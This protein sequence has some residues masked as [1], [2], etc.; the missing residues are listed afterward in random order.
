MEHMFES[1]VSSIKHSRVRPLKDAGQDMGFVLSTFR[2]D[3]WVGWLP[4]TS[5]GMIAPP[6]HSYELQEPTISEYSSM[7]FQDWCVASPWWERH[8]LLWSEGKGLRVYTQ[9]LH[10]LWCVSWRTSVEGRHKFEVPL[11]PATEAETLHCRISNQ[12]YDQLLAYL[13]NAVES[14]DLISFRVTLP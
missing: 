2:G 12:L 6:A 10:H 8:Q 4:K 5:W 7:D 14:R 9:Q 3:E 1:S 13:V 11:W